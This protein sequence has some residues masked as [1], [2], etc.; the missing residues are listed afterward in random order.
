MWDTISRVA[1]ATVVGVSV[2]VATV[3]AVPQSEVSPASVTAGVQLSATV[4]A[5]GGLGYETLEQDLIKRVLG[6][7]YASEENLVGLPWP[8]ELAPFNGT[9]TLNQSVAVGL[10]NMDAAIRSTPG[11]KI[12]A[13]ASGSTLVVNEVMR[14]L[15][16]DPAAPPKEELSFVVLGDADR[17]VL[18]QF[19]GLTL[20]IFDYTVSAL[21]VTEYDVLVVTGEYDGLGDWPDRPWNLLAVVNALAGTGLLQQVIPQEIVDALGLEGF[22]SVH[23]DAMFADLARV[24]QKN[25]STEVNS[26]GGVTTTY[27]VPTPDLPMLRPLRTL[28]VPQDVVDTLEKGLRPIVDSAYARNDPFRTVPGVGSTRR[29]EAASSATAAAVA[30]AATTDASAPAAVKTIEAPDSKRAL[31]GSRSNDRVAD[32]PRRHRSS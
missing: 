4:L 17:G 9:L 3:V 13:G 23:Y 18:K 28:G 10:E 2:G 1:A 24:P 25:I 21:P 20:P 22:G 15:G 14:R 27:V 11:P 16:H 5:M 6:G 8:G 32:S 29:P 7:R 26:L 12:V 30:P 19:R 31:S